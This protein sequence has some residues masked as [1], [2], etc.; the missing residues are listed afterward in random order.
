M[1]TRSAIV[2]KTGD[3]TFSGRFVHFDGYP[4]GVGRDL[5]RL[6]HGPF[7]RNMERMLAAVIDG[8]Q[9]PWLALDT[10]SGI[11]GH[12]IQDGS[13]PAVTER[14]AGEWGCCY[15]YQFD[16]APDGGA[17]MSVLLRSPQDDGSVPYPLLAEIA[18]DGPEADWTELDGRDA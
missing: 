5:W 11:G 13:A 2:R 9:G 3:S 4:S 1:S 18:L 10:H 17:R 6:Y 8:R 7:A 14:N 16:A 12:G 15:V